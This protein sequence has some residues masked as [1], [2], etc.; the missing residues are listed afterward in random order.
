M[1]DTELDQVNAASGAPGERLITKREL[2]AKIH[3][4]VR[5][6]D[7][8]IRRKRIPYFKIGRSVLFRWSVVLQHLESEFGVN[9]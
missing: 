5:T 3:R 4:S 1:I 6:V 7:D 8:W 9:P 2:A